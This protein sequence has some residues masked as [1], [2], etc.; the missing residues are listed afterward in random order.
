MSKAGPDVPWTCRQEEIVREK[1]Y[2]GAAGV[3]D[4]ILRETGVKRTVRSV[5]AH[6]SRI[7]VSLKVKARCPE[8]GAIGVRLVRTTGMC[9]RCTERLHVEEERI[10][11]EM[12]QA[13]ATGCEEGPEYEALKREYARLRQANS[14]L[15]RKYGLQGK[16][17]RGGDARAAVNDA[18]A[19]FLVT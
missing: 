19:R 8:C 16:R 11:G 5:E 7:H 13:E 4:A 10:Y 18:V 12:L 3:R 17:E 1:S 15:S 2:L 14:R 6:A 9:P